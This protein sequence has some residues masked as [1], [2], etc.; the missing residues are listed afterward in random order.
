MCDHSP[1]REAAM[2]HVRPGVWCDPCLAPLVA[3]LNAAGLTTVASCCGHG[4]RPGRVSLADGR[5]LLI[6]PNFETAERIDALF[7]VDIN[8]EPRP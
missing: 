4:H 2:V 6:A 1:N 3:L 8:G 7:P 5:E